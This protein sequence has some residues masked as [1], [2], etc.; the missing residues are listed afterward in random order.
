MLQLPPPVEHINGCRLGYRWAARTN[1]AH[2]PVGA[3]GTRTLAGPGDPG[4][5]PRT[6]AAMGQ[7]LASELSSDG[8]RA[9]PQGFVFVTQNH[10]VELPEAKIWF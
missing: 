8:C 5:G 7:V 3:L 10:I 6:C 9:V 1:P 4:I 2:L